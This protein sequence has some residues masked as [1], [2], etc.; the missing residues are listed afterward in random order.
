MAFCCSSFKD[1]PE[2]PKGSSPDR[3]KV[4]A[5]AGSPR[6]EGSVGVRERPWVCCAGG[7]LQVATRWHARRRTHSLCSL[8]SSTAPPPLPPST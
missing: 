4:L 7:A 6:G 8:L 2:L 3:W 5:C 1:G